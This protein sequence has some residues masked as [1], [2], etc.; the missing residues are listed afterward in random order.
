MNFK[1][2]VNIVFYSIT[3]VYFMCVLFAGCSFVVAL[4]VGTDI[5]FKYFLIASIIEIIFS[6]GFFFTK[7]KTLDSILLT[8]CILLVALVT[9]KDFINLSF[10]EYPN[11]FKKDYKSSSSDVILILQQKL[12]NFN[13]KYMMNMALLFIIILML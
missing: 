5:I 1:K 2:F 3:A 4:N 9:S 7:T 8:I 10:K 13:K 11:L 6:I 12:V